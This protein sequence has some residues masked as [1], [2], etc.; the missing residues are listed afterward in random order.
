V[1]LFAVPGTAV[2]GAQPR[3]KRH[4]ILEQRAGSPGRARSLA[5]RL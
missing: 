3:L 5:A 2:R 1:G 4:Q